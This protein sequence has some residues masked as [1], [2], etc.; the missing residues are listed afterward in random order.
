[1][2]E[3]ASISQSWRKN[4][5]FIA[6][7]LLAL[8]VTWQIINRANYN[9]R[10]QQQA[11]ELQA[12]NNLLEQQARNQSLDNEFLRSD[13]YLDLAIREQQGHV[14]P[15]ESSLIISRQ[16]ISQLKAAYRPK[17]AADETEQAVPSNFQQWR[18]FVS[19]NDKR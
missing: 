8:L 12:E 16:K 15:G 2:K 6:A 11:N 1:M 17:A 10:L 9:Y 5:P 3:I 18:N 7:L 4:L 13:Y 14:L 19:G